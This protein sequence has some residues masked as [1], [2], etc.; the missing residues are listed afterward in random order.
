[1]LRLL[2]FLLPIIPDLSALP[3]L[4]AKLSVPARPG[5]ARENFFCPAW[6]GPLYFVL[7]GPARFFAGGQAARS[8]ALPV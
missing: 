8:G 1:M 2:D 5:P 4:P 3:D 6:P 7:P